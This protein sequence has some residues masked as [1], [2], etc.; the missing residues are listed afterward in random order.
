MK[1]L[2]II[3]SLLLMGHQ[4]CSANAM[5]VVHR[6][7]QQSHS[8]QQGIFDRA[9]KK[10]EREENEKQEA[11]DFIQRQ[12]EEE[13]IMAQRKANYEKNYKRAE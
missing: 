11:I 8:H 2:P 6:L 4:D 9:M 12:K 1:Q 10:I 5:S 7:R 3:V 13:E